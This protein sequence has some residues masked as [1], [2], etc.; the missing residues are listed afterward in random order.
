[1]S[2]LRPCNDCGRHVRSAD[3]ECPFCG[4][5]LAPD[6]SP[7]GSARVAT[8]L[9]RAAIFAGAALL[10]PACGSGS[11]ETS[12][13]D[14]V[15]QTSGGGDT[16]QTNGEGQDGDAQSGDREPDPVTVA[17]PYGAAPADDPLRLV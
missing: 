8:R 10:A 11:S 5:E 14:Q 17:P 12:Q 15:E 9:T 13:Q 1:M 7:P 4:A 6:A 3:P 2:E 16:Q